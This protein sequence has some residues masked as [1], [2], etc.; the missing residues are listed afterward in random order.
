MTQLKNIIILVLLLMAFGLSAK[1]QSSALQPYEGATHTYTWNGLQ[2]GVSYDF[3]ITASANGSGRYDDV[4]TGEF[5]IFN[6]TGTVDA[7]GLAATDITWNS[8]ASDHIYYCWLQVTNS[9]GCSNYRYVEVMPQVNQFD[10]LSENIPVDNTISCPAVANEDGFN[11]GSDSYSAGYTMLQFKVSRENGTDNSLTASTD[12]TYDW[13]FIPELTVD[14]SLTDK[15]NVIISVSNSTN[16]GTR[17]TVGGDIDE[18]LV[19]VSIEN[20]PGEDL[21]VTL[22]VTGQQEENTNL[23]DSEPTNDAVTHTIQVMPVI[24]GMGGV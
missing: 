15:V 8:G 9:N 18:V 11:P 4:L 5:D 12:D 20:A 6:A 19:T 23:S 14:P 2:E 1:A 24:N 16:D 10:L 17:Y 21:D 13:S 7:D 22:E 3:Y